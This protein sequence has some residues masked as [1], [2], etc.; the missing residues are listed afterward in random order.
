[1]SRILELKKKI[2]PFG[3]R[4]E[5][6]KRYTPLDW[7][8]SRKVSKLI[9]PFS[10]DR[11]IAAL[12][13]EGK[14]ALVGRLGGTEARFLGEYLKL[15]SL[16]KLGLPISMTSKILPRW[17]RRKLEVFTNAGFYSKNWNEV[18]TFAKEYLDGLKNSDVLGA[19]GVAFAWAEGIDLDQHHTKLIPVGFTAPW[20]EPYAIETFSQKTIPWSTALNG[21]RVLVVSGFAQS[22]EL[23]HRKNGSFFK[24]VEYPSFNLITVRAPMTSGQIDSMGRSWF[25]LLEG[26]KNEIQVLDFDVALIAAGAYSYPLANFVKK[27]GRVGIH[28]G[29]GLQLFFGIMGNRW[30]ESSEVLKYVNSEWIRPSSSERPVNAE[31][32]E[33]ACYW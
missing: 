26:L 17:K 12:I 6:A 29:G 5:I 4:H 7:Y 24:G 10:A 20:V 21:K 23:Q 11:E 16:S 1:M 30:N 3:F 25:E 32:I 19:W 13:N 8:K 28:C 9:D 31:S 15:K 2:A 18:D 33:D 22:I 14:P 27:M